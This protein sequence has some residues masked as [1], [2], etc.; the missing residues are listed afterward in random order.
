MAG[1]DPRSNKASKNVPGFLGADGA[2]QG[3]SSLAASLMFLLKSL[4]LFS[5]L[6]LTYMHSVKGIPHGRFTRL[7]FT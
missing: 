2:L 5:W 6:K 1:Q 4:F 7:D 3:T